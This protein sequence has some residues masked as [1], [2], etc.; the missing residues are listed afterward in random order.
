M[1]KYC[2]RDT[3]RVA[4]FMATVRATCLRVTS[5]MKMSF[6]ISGMSPNRSFFHLIISSLI[7]H[8]DELIVLMTENKF[9]FDFFGFSE[10]CMCL[11]K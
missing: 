2:R 1:F 11:L 4:C 5:A 10:Q 7:F 9:N 6:F 3:V 8:F